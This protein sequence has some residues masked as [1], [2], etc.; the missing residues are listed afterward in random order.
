MVEYI[1]KNCGEIKE[2]NMQHLSDEEV[3][4][5]KQRDDNVI[6]IVFIILFVITMIIWR[7]I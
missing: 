3:K 5:M 7:I 6:R 2:D 1:C 4:E